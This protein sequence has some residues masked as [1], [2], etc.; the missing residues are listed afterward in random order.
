MV[1]E[2]KH[3]NTEYKD[4]DTFTCE[5]CVHYS[6]CFLRRNISDFMEQHFQAR[7]PFDTSELAKIC[8]DYEPIF[9]MHYEQ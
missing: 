9:M 7:K 6:V 5:K 8:N 3:Q 2:I 4:E 1:T